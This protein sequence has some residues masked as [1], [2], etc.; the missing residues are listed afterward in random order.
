M[1]SAGKRTSRDR[2]RFRSPTTPSPTAR[3]RS[4]NAVGLGEERGTRRGY[5]LIEIFLEWPTPDTW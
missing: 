5:F 1:T 3:P 4:G 2:T